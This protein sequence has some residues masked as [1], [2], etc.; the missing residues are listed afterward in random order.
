MKQTSRFRTRA[1]VIA[2][3]AVAI[4]ASVS[5][6]QASATSL[7]YVSLG[8]SFAAG[9]GVP[10]R[11][12]GSPAGCGRSTNNFAHVVAKTKDYQLT[13][14]S[15]GGAQVRNL[16]ISQL[17]G[18]GPQ[19]EALRADT[20]LV[21]LLIGYNDSF[22]YTGSLNSC[23][24]QQS[25]GISS[26]VMTCEARNGTRFADAINTTTASAIAGALSDIKSKSPHARVIVVGYPAIFPQRGNCRPQN[27]YSVAD[28]AYLNGIEKDLN[29][30]LAREAGDAG[31][32]Y[33]DT[34]TPS[35]PYNSCT[36]PA[37]RW[38][39]PRTGAIG[40]STQHPNARGEN[41]IAQQV[42]A[43]IGP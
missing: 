32:E 23:A 9:A 40:A 20:D 31:V 19:F 36:G 11:V 18:Q 1:A 25:G 3:I 16:E 22:V 35:I 43:K 27:P 14:V 12:P 29:A 8:A 42:L 34:F 6:P 5:A 26:E 41:G 37:T 38:I 7:S 10:E 2:S 33:V 24:E 4:A 39:E 13:D 21:T 30:M 28:T 17:E 15:C